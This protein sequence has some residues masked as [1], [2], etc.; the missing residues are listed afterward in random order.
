MSFMLKK[1][2]YKFEVD[3]CLV[4]L[5]EVSHSKGTFFAKI[6]QMDGG[7]FTDFSRRW[8]IGKLFGHFL[9]TNSNLAPADSTSLTADFAFLFS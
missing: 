1:K 9:K 3:L 8:N 6:R 4:E 7:S 2:R 5:S